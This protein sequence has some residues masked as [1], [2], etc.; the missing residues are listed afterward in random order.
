LPRRFS[1]LVPMRANVRQDKSWSRV[2][3][4]PKAAVARFR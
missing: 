2:T 3:E 1:S 4:S